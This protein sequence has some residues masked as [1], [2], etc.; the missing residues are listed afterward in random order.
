MRGL[1]VRTIR[2]VPISVPIGRTGHFTIAGELGKVEAVEVHYFGPRRNEVLNELLLG[3]G[4]SIDFRYRAQLGV[5]TE[6]Q[7]DSRSGPV[8]LVGF[9]VAPFVHTFR[10]GGWP[11]FRHH[12]ERVAKE[13][14]L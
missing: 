8:D 2:L 5:R 9:P 11:P 13:S 7:V 1:G 6:D 3:V 10:H 4:T 14:V 12:V